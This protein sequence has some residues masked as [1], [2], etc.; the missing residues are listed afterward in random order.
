MRQK[1]SRLKMAYLKLPN[2][3]KRFVCS[4]LMKCL[5]TNNDIP[6]HFD[7]PGLVSIHKNIP[8]PSPGVHSKLNYIFSRNIGNST[9]QRKATVTTMPWPF[10]IYPFHRR[11]RTDEKDIQSAVELYSLKYKACSVTMGLLNKSCI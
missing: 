1:T 7:G 9:P 2:D 5:Y 6:P 3:F 11:C 8:P 10:H 4:F